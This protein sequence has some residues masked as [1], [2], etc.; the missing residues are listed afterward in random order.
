MPA[1]KT[2]SNKTPQQYAQQR[3]SDKLF[4]FKIR[5]KLFP[6][7]DKFFK[8]RPEVTGMAAEDDTIILNPYSKL[9]K[10]NLGL[11][12]QNEALRLKM[13]TENFTPNIDV[14]DEQKDF[15]KGTEYENNPQAMRQ[16]IFARIYSGDPSAMA[17]PEQ[18]QALKDYLKK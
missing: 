11:V 15:F 18:I 1:K 8:N 12:A 7:E 10:K 17:T 9:S 14:T 6:G 13:R 4:G 5:T 2:P 3:A 16:T